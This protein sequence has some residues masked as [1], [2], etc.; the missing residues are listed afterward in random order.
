M[1]MEGY[2]A[3]HTTNASVPVSATVI[4]NKCCLLLQGHLL[5]PLRTR[6]RTGLLPTS[7]GKLK[8]LPPYRSKTIQ[9]V[10]S[11]PDPRIARNLT[12]SLPTTQKNP[13]FSPMSRKPRDRQQLLKEHSLRRNMDPLSG[14]SVTTSSIADV[15]PHSLH[16]QNSTLARVD[17]PNGETRPVT[18]IGPSR[19]N[20][21][22]SPIRGPLN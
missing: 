8:A 7:D 14:T 18:R 16:L 10:L 6:P 21:E 17:L 2:P 22:D 3:R 12:L 9:L 5:F 11:F 1:K 20:L 15:Q 19:T 13:P 4:Q